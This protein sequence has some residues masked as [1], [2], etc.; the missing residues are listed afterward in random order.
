MEGM[1]VVRTGTSWERAMGA[2]S[3]EMLVGAPGFEP[4]TSCAQGK[5]A[6]RLRHAPMNDR[7]VSGVRFQGK[8]NHRSPLTL[9]TCPNTQFV[10]FCQAS[11]RLS[12]RGDRHERH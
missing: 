4:G 6:T 10:P 12:S 9:S 5:R 11:V 1:S 2:K 3:F 8:E 7:V